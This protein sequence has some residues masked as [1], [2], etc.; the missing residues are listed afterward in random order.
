MDTF[1]AG[2]YSSYL[3]SLF[4]VN[5]SVLGLTTDY[6]SKRSLH[7]GSIDRHPRGEHRGFGLLSHLDIGACLP[8]F[9]R[10]QVYPYGK[11][12]YLFQHEEGYTEHNAQSLNNHIRARNTDVLRSELGLQGRYC[13]STKHQ[14]SSWIPS[15]RLGWVRETRFHGQR[16]HARLVDVPNGYSVIG[17]YPVRSMLVAGASLTAILVPQT[18]YISATYEGLFCGKFSSNEGSL[19]LNLEF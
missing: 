1:Y 16:I 19:E 13:Y 14:K 3:S 9:S 11:L 10:A 15:A 17:L 5:A 4:F 2:L 7:F 18:V 8:K 6:H 12:D